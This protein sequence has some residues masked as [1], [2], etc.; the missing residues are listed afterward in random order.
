MTIFK[1]KVYYDKRTNR[2]V[3]VRRKTWNYLVC[4]EF[5]EWFASAKTVILEQ[6]LSR[7]YIKGCVE[8]KALDKASYAM[9]DPSQLSW[10][11][12]QAHP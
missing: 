5:T 12:K 2:F 8:V 4:G 6:Q 11:V 10:R 7:A 3:Q 9:L 1:G